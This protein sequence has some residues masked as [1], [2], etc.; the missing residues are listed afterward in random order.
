MNTGVSRI[1]V[2]LV[3]V[4]ALTLVLD[5]APTGMCTSTLA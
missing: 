5:T 1:N 2:S 4:I 3:I